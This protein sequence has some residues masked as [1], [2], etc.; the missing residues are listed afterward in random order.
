MSDNPCR[1]LPVDPEPQDGDTE[2]PVVEVIEIGGPQFP[3]LGLPDPRDDMGQPTARTSTIIPYHLYVEE[4][5]LSAWFGPYPRPPRGF[6]PGQDQ[7]GILNGV[8]SDLK[9]TGE[10]DPFRYSIGKV[11]NLQA[12]MNKNFFQNPNVGAGRD[13]PRRYFIRTHPS[14]S[15]YDDEPVVP[16]RDTLQQFHNDLVVSIP[17]DDLERYSYW[18]VNENGEEY[19]PTSEEFFDNL[20]DRESVFHDN[21]FQAP[22]SFFER[23]AR[24][25]NVSFG[26]QTSIQVFVPKI[27]SY[28]EHLNPGDG[29]LIDR[30]NELQKE[31]LYHRY[32]REYNDVLAGSDITKLQA[33]KFPSSKI[34][35]I[36]EITTLATNLT[37]DG[38][39]SSFGLIFSSEYDM[40][41]RIKFNMNHQ[42]P[43]AEKME[44]LNL[45]AAILGMLE[46]LAPSDE[47]RK[48]T[49]IL[50]Q[51]YIN[52]EI[53]GADS[54]GN[55]RVSLNFRPRAYE[56]FQASFLEKLGDSLFGRLD[57]DQIDYIES[58]MKK[59][60]F[61]LLYE[62]YE[63]FDVQSSN[64][65]NPIRGWSLS[66]S[67]AMGL[68]LVHIDGT[69]REKDRS[70]KKVMDNELCHSEVIAYRVEKVSVATGAVVQDFY[71]FNSQDVNELDFIDTQIVFGKKYRYR[72]YTIN[73]VLGCEYEYGNFRVD[74]G[75]RNGT[76]V[77]EARGRITQRR[78]IDIIEAP[79]F[80]QELFVSDAP[81]LTPDVW[82]L[83]V[84]T[85]SGDAFW[86][87]F[88]PAIG[89]TIERPIP[90]RRDDF[91]T[92]RRMREQQG[93]STLGDG[94]I[95]YKSDTD[96]THYEMLTLEDPPLSY[97]DF[98]SADLDETTIFA[99]SFVKNNLIPNKDYY[100]TFRARDLAGISNPT[101][102]FKFTLNQYPN[103]SPYINI[104]VYDFESEIQRQRYE[105]TSNGAVSIDPALQQ[106]AINFSN[107]ENY[108]NIDPN[109]TEF[110]QSTRGTEGLTLG[111]RDSED[112]VWGKKFC[113]EMVSKTTGKKIRFMIKYGQEVL[114]SQAQE[115]EPMPQ[116]AQQDPQQNNQGQS[117]RQRP[118][119]EDPSPRRTPQRRRLEELEA[120]SPARRP[121]NGG[122]GY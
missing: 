113:I 64:S 8:V 111:L 83:P 7:Q 32:M 112:A 121:R 46:Q 40:Y 51:E 104:E 78:T 115:E 99:N 58:A 26:E 42:S 80:E 18:F 96:P 66:K 62:E 19:I 33:H 107:S 47:E 92:I 81:P 106:T 82:F 74:E 4:D 67:I 52:P 122:G 17:L 76:P 41:S 57:G 37:V 27:E 39:Y 79:Y 24:A 75:S 50:D 60:S 90:L 87:W 59:E 97:L 108:R 65:H 61:P 43:I 22:A 91:A 6:I 2:I 44:E 102:V 72:I 13:T 49:Q 30:R 94:E 117:A 95:T 34:R 25:L 100:I 9:G 20:I 98:D 28:S 15:F 54:G 55:D 38:L 11:N 110:V 119:R 35:Q 114:E 105:I 1:D 103:E 109:S 118:A 71:F 68:A 16:N 63:R 85:N 45:D 69:M 31:G 29:S 36:N 12:E 116:P 23:E 70:F 3:E 93:I 77:A 21:S 84:S 86:F 56:N 88:S 101:R 73:F 14:N 5:I 120:E 48:Y 53:I 10:I 89:E